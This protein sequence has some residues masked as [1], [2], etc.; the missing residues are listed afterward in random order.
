MLASRNR[1]DQAADAKFVGRAPFLLG[2]R[3]ALQRAYA[4]RRR[5]LG[6]SFLFPRRAGEIRCAKRG[7]HPEGEKRAVIGALDRREVPP[8]LQ[9]AAL[10]PF[11][12]MREPEPGEVG[13]HLICIAETLK[14]RALTLLLEI[15]PQHNV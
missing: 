11:E 2:A 9:T 3:W 6:L 10:S 7:G 1:A 12:P 15:A 8:L 4:P 5:S 13:F 14:N